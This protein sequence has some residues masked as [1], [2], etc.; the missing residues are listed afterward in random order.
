MKIK[1]GGKYRM[2][3][4]PTP[5]LYVYIVCKTKDIQPDIYEWQENSFY[6][7]IVEE[8]KLTSVK[9]LFSDFLEFGENGSWD[10]AEVH[11]NFH[12]SNDLVEEL[13]LPSEKE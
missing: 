9:Y 11:G 7:V 12:D 10:N 3:D 4:Y 5:Y 13:N 8:S 6:G 1:V 2:R